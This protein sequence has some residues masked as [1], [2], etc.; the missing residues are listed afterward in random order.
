LLSWSILLALFSAAIW[1]LKISLWFIIV[2]GPAIVVCL[3][4]LAT[5][6]SPRLRKGMM[7]AASKIVTVHSLGAQGSEKIN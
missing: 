7:D 2:S 3:G 4:I 5:A 6:L 1:L